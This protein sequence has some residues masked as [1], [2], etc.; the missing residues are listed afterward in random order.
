LFGDRLRIGLVVPS[1]N[2]TAEPELNAMAPS[3]VSLHS[4]RVYQAETESAAEKIATVL[5]MN[6][7][8]EGAVRQLMSVRPGVIAFGCTAASFLGGR[9][10]DV[11][12]SHRLGSAA[13]VPFLTTSSAVVT[14]LRALRVRRLALGT[15]Y[16]DE[17]NVR[18]CR[19]L[20]EALGIEVVSVLGLQIVGNLPKGRL[21]P[22][23]AW[24]VALSV[25]R[26]EADAVFLSC[27]NWRTAES[28][29]ALERTLGKPVLTSNQA[30]LW[31][32]LRTAGLLDTLPR[33]GR[34]MTLTA[35]PRMEAAQA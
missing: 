30:T 23:A 19:Y 5:A 21:G 22:E 7:E 27:T 29:V 6:A 18:E 9:D 16:I 34:L 2:T 17:V 20:E 25:D 28:I 35:P 32:C 11:R 33:F 26:P 8:L 31:A 14:A 3:G 24:D 12:L 4:T 10:E 15:P 1:S 13:S